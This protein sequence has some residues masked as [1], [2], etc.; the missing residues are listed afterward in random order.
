MSLFLIFFVIVL[1]FFANIHIMN[2]GQANKIISSA[3]NLGAGR[4]GL[5]ASY[6]F[7][8]HIFSNFGMF[9]VSGPITN[10]NS[11]LTIL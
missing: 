7:M 2:V 4:V 10:E 3:P 1:L 11:I 5:L 6:G 8:N 9:Y